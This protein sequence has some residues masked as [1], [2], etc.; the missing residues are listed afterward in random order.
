MNQSE[1]LDSNQCHG[2]G[3]PEVTL[4]DTTIGNKYQRTISRSNQ[5]SYPHIV[6]TSPNVSAYTSEASS[7]TPQNA[8]GF[9]CPLGDVL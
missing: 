9:T 2:L 5:L 7:K 1:G 4:K 8:R 6:N 3:K